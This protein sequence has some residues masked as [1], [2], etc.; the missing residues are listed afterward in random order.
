MDL[1]VFYSKNSPALNI[2]VFFCF[3][4]TFGNF[5]RKYTK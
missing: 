5:L 1:K 4:H 2:F 3:V